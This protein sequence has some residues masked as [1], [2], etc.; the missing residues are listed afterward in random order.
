MSEDEYRDGR[1]TSPFSEFRRK[2][3]NEEAHVLEEVKVRIGKDIRWR[4]VDWR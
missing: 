4:L 2:K 3:R 1:L